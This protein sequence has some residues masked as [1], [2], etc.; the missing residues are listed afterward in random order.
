MNQ[1]PRGRTDRP[2]R[3]FLCGSD[4]FQYPE[5]FSGWHPMLICSSDAGSNRTCR[6]KMGGHRAAAGCTCRRPALQAHPGS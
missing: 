5:H 3:F 2:G 6:S 4:I 1:H